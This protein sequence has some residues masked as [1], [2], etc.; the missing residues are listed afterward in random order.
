MAGLSAQR[1]RGAERSLGRRAPLRRG[2]KGK[3]I[4]ITQL[5]STFHYHIGN[6]LEKYG[7]G[8]DDVKIVP[9]QAMGAAWRPS[10]ASRSTPSCCPSRSPARPRRRASAGSSRG[11]AICFP[12][13]SRRSSTRRKF[14]AERARAVD[15]MKG[16]VKARATTTTPRSSRR[17]AASRP[18][19][20]TRRWSPS[21]RSTRARSP[22]IIRLGFPYQD[23]NGR[24]L[25]EDIGKQMA[26]WHTHGFMKSVLP[27]QRGGGHALHRGRHP[28][29][30]GMTSPH[31][32]VLIAN[33]GEIAVRVIR[34]CRELGIATVAVY[35][36]ADRESLHVLM[37][38]EAYPIGPR[39]RGGELPRIDQLVEVA[40]ASGADA[41]HPGYGFLSENAALR[42]GVRGRGPDLRR[43]AARGHPGH[44]RQDGRAPAG[45][46]AGR[47]RGAGHR[48]AVGRDAR[49]RAR[50]RARSAIP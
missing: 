28:R 34:A 13:R 33:R 40:R 25:V 38:D 48:R 39:A 23:R 41:V 44:G 5:G 15:F 35:S 42:R 32:K 8:L 2:L 6:I 3:R 31:R 18:G 46:R 50:W 4:G 22:E 30:G 36:E 47:A 26:W 16:Y 11:P 12:G 10:R 1:D 19:A 29:R 21:P 43:A 45:A 20:P 7:L 17:T 14:A 27:V 37:A 9:L 24:L 49:R